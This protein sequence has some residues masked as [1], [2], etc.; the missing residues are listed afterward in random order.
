MNINKYIDWGEIWENEVC[1]ETSMD[2]ME[3]DNKV[4]SIEVIKSFI[5]DSEV[6][7]LPDEC[8]Y[9]NPFLIFCFSETGGQN[10][11]DTQGWSRDYRFVVDDDFIIVD[12]SYE[13]G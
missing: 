6:E 5:K 13:Q 12:A 4:N 1:L 2:C 11:S 10:E 8:Y 3:D 7:L 9:Q